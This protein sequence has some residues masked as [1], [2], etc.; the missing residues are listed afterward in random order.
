VKSAAD[1]DI[2]R[3]RAFSTTTSTYGHAKRSVVTAHVRE[4]AT[5][6]DD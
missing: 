2:V 6:A 4:R 3:P 1:S 5:A